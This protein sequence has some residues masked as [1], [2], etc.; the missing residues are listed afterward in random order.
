M[1]VRQMHSSLLS[2]IKDLINNLRFSPL[3]INTPFSKEQVNVFQLKLA[4]YLQGVGHP[5]HP[6]IP[7]NFITPTM[8]AE[9]AHDHLYCA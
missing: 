8:R 2:S 7:E 1:L 5:A 3:P 6:L 9:V 4:C